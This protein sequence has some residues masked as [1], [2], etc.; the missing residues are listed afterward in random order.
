MHNFYELLKQTHLSFLGVPSDMQQACLK[1][2]LYTQHLTQHLTLKFLLF[3]Q[4]KPLVEYRCS[5]SMLAASHGLHNICITNI[6][7][8]KLWHQR[9]EKYVLFE[10]GNHFQA[11][12]PLTRTTLLSSPLFHFSSLLSTPLPLFISPLPHFSP[13]LSLPF[14]P[15][16]LSSLPLPFHS[17]LFSPLPVS[18]LP[19]LLSS[20][21]PVPI[22]FI[23]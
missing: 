20:P 9:G 11:L 5:S 3:S 14:F 4:E 18:P 21:L 10:S 12:S 17:L 7:S 15:P 13:L 2:I 22:L 8:Q 19:F 16:L 6:S 23:L 1:G